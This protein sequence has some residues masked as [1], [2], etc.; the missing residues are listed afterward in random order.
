MSTYNIPDEALETLGESLAGMG[1]SVSVENSSD[2]PSESIVESDHAEEKEATE[3]DNVS[4]PVVEKES[5][6]DEGEVKTEPEASTDADTKKEEVPPVEVEA[7]NEVK[8]ERPNGAQRAIN[9]EVARRKQ[10]EERNK[11]LE[12]RMLELMPKEESEAYKSKQ[13][14]EKVKEYEANSHAQEAKTYFDEQVNQLSE[15]DRNTLIQNDTTAFEDKP[16]S[17]RAIQTATN[18][19]EVLAYM[20]N[21]PRHLE[22]IQSQS[23]EFAV[24]YLNVVADE[25]A[26]VKSQQAQVVP[27]PTEQ[28]LQPQVQKN[29]PKPT[30]KLSK[31]PSSGNPSFNPLKA[32][33]EETQEWLNG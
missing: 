12:D 30:P 6:S 21:N 32:T 8:R 22:V 1:E 24:Q 19:A 23:D 26:N 13:L 31:M 27:Q 2:E 3:E 7:K 25:M 33:H 9:R 20:A 10:A 28:A 14:E 16:F 5:E 15:D 29:V 4:E 18:G 11:A 17:T